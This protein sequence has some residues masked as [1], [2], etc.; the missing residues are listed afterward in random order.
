PIEKTGHDW[1]FLLSFAPYES[2]LLRCS[3][4]AEEQASEEIAVESQ[5]WTLALDVRQPWKLSA[6]QDNNV[7]LGT[8]RFALDQHHTGLQKRWHEGEIDEAWPIVE[9]KPIVNQCA[10]IAAT[11]TFPLQFKQTFGI[12][13]RSSLAYPL[14]CWYHSAFFVAETPPACQLVMDEGAI[15]GEYTVYLNGQRI[16]AANFKPAAP[17]GYRQQ[18]REVVSFLK[19]GINHLVIQLEAG[20]DEDGV[21]DPLYLC[22]PFGVTFDD[23]G[24]AIIGKAPA[25]GSPRSDVQP[26]YPYYA[27]TLCFSREITIGVLPNEPTF[28]VM[29]QGWDKYIH[30]CVEV[31]V[32]GHSLGVCCWS[33]YRWRGASTLLRQGSNSVEIRVTNTLS[34]LLEGTYFDERSHQMRPVQG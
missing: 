34:G 11:Q 6:W 21:R 13:A 33:P 25:T 23:Q 22:G 1:W 24:M 15:G 14:S 32:N 16:S 2:Y 17:H 18:S 31:V 29:L 12:P 30:D 7:R 10:D 4:R 20:R 8:F 26:G 9:S 28:E 5:P 3:F 19:P 27:G